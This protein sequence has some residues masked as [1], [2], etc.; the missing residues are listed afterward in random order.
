M[1]TAVFTS[2]LTLNHQN[3]GRWN[4]DANGHTVSC[5]YIKD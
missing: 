4:S 3:P 1:T 2:Y 5:Y